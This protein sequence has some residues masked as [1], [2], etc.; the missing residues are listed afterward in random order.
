MAETDKLRCANPACRRP[1]DQ[2][3]LGR[4]RST[5]SNACRQAV[6][7]RNRKRSRPRVRC[8]G[9]GDPVPRY[10]EA[11]LRKWLREYVRDNDMPE[12]TSWCRRCL[13]LD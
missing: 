9:C 2:A 5:C 11:W 12:G 1:L 6:Y 7:R 10:G 13:G 3:Q 4:R 8:H